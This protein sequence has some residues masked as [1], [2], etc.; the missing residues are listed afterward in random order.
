MAQ[1]AP[2]SG[3]LP[4]ARSPV[5][6]PVW[7]LAVFG[8]AFGLMYLPTFITLSQTVWA[9]DEQGHGPLILAACAWLLWGMRDDLFGP[10]AKP[11]VVPGFLLL[12]LGLLMYVV[13]RSQRVIEFEASSLILV[14]V[15]GMLLLQGIA[16]LRR[17]WFPFLFLLFMVPLPGALVQAMTLPLKSAVS[18]VAEQILYWAGYPIGRTGVTLTIG[19][20]QLLVADACSGLNSLFTL[21]SL[22][23]LYMNIMNYKSK[24]RNTILAIGI[25]PISFIANVTRVII[26]V[27]ITYHLGDEVGQ[28]F[29]HEFAGL[30]LFSVALVLTYG[31]DRL[32]AARFD[33]MGGARDGR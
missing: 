30:V 17:A 27:L 32:L 2:T 15:S 33:D 3:A 4:S 23:L 24:A 28:G 16:A 13:G 9:T 22:G 5:K 29:A 6:F 11:A 7:S 20:Y 1:S 26:L 31:L 19:P 12:L 10:P 25:V 18:V 21:E 8:V 14:L